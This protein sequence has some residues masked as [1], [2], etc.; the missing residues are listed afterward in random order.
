MKSVKICC[1][2]GRCPEIFYDMEGII[3][4]DEMKKEV[5][6]THEEFQ[7]L[8]DKIIKGDFTVVHE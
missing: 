2:R 3:I 8:K 1:G 6:F 4:R 7:V 5:S